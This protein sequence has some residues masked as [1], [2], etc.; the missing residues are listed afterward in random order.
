MCVAVVMK[1]YRKQVSSSC[2]ASVH[3]EIT[4]FTNATVGFTD[5]ID[6]QLMES[7]RITTCEEREKYVAVLMDEMHIKE[8]LVHDKHTGTESYFCL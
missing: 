2:Q 1:C 4:Y 8:D 6:K 3:S 7:V 5:D